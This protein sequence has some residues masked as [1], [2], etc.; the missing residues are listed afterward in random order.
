MAEDL[1]KKLPLMSGAEDL[2]R[3]LKSRGAK[4]AVVSGG[5]TLFVK[6]LV[7]L[8]ELDFSSSNELEI[9]NKK[10]TGKILGSIVNASRKEEFLSELSQRLGL[11][12]D[13]VVAV[14]DGANDIL[15]LKKSG[16]GIAFCAKEK[17][18]FAAHASI[19][20]QNLLSILHLISL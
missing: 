10:L 13:Q 15:M 7:D 20:Q 8:L 6:E 1:S 5:F 16:L 18:K 14:G 11:S 12:L 4:V 2:I 9:E 3:A 19:T 17:T